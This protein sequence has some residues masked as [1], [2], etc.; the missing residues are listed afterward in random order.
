MW[1]GV[2]NLVPKYA[3]CF[4]FDILHT[5]GGNYRQTRLKQATLF[6][7]VPSSF[8]WWRFGYT[9]DGALGDGQWQVVG[10]VL[11]LS[12]TYSWVWN[13]SHIVL[14]SS[15]P[16][17]EV[18]DIL[19]LFQGLLWQYRDLVFH[20]KV[21][22]SKDRSGAWHWASLDY[23]TFEACPVPQQPIP[24]ATDLCSIQSK[25]LL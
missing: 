24:P 9:T 25:Y 8:A 11:H 14:V 15:F 16:R 2:G 22:N 23:T 17:V 18:C 6:V 21:F 10:S 13:L 1:C 7:S 12:S 3:V 5:G 19:T 20:L 4:I